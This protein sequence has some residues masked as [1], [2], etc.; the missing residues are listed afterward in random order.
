MTG[1][2]QIMAV[3][4]ALLLGACVTAQEPLQDLAPGERPDISSDEGG[5]WMQMDSVEERLKTSGH[6]VN[7]PKLNAYVRDITCRLSQEYCKH[8]RLFIVQTPHFNA[9]MAPN[10]TMQVWTGTLLR[11]QNE[12]QLAYVIGHEMAHYIRRHSVQQWR[13][14]RGSSDRMAFLTVTTRMAGLGF[15]G[16]LADLAAMS[17]IMAFSRDHERESDEIGFELTEKAGYAAAEAPKIWENI[18][19]EREAAGADKPSVFFASHPTG[20]ERIGTLQAH[21]A[22]AGPRGEIRQKQF[23]AAIAPHRGK[24]LRDEVRKRDFEG[25]QFLLENLLAAGY[26]PGE[27]HYYQGEL[28]RLR[29]ED[30]D[31]AA[32]ISAYRKALAS[33]GAPAE[34]HRELGLVYWKSNQPKLARKSFRT[35]LAAAPKAEDRAM[36]KSYIDQLK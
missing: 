23:L 31:F 26:R 27:I 11:V 15:V 24:W 22:A 25:T 10:G 1:A 5:L 32:A 13:S 14:I 6:V 29:G 2:R 3:A 21:A 8:L 28:H 33:K 12:A 20:E 16:D 36:V 19:A 34:T 9:S 18:L 17:S 7:D 30:G 35:Y 4:A